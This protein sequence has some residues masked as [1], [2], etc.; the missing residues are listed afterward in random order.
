VGERRLA[1][2]MFTDM[3]GYTA[4]SQK[5]EQRAMLQLDEHRKLV[6]PIFSRHNGHEVKTIGDAFL[7]EFASALEAVRCAFDIQQCLHELNSTRTVDDRMLLRISVHV[8]D[9]IH[10]GN[11]VYGDAVNVASRM[12]PLA[13]PGGIC[14]SEQVY[15]HVRNKFEFPLVSLGRKELKNVG[16]GVELYRVVLPWEAEAETVLDKQ[17][18]AVLPFDSLS[19]D[20]NDEYFADGLTEELIDRL[21]QIGGL[22]VIART[23]V[24]SYKR[25]GKKAAEIARELSVGSLVEGSVRK[26]GNKVRVTAQLINGVTE[27]HLWSSRY[28]KSLD[29]IFAVQSDIAEQVSDALKIRLLPNESEAIKKKATV[30]TEAHNLFLKGRHF[31]SQRNPES[32]QRAIICFEQAVEIDPLFALAYV[33][34]ADCYLV[35]LDQSAVEPTGIDQKIESLAGRALELDSGLA[36][37]HA[38]LANLLQNRWNW[39]EAEAEYKRAIELN[40]NYATSHH[41]YSILL[42]RF[43][44]FDQALDEIRIAHRLDP[45][46]PM[47]NVN[48]GLRLVEAGHL[49]EGLEQLRSS[50]QLDP[51]FGQGHAQLGATYVGMGRYEEGILELEK[52]DEIMAGSPWAKALLAYTFGMKGEQAKAENY[53]KEIENLART[54]YVPSALLGTVYFALGQKEKA[55]ELFQRAYDERSIALE[56]VREFLVYRPIREDQRI[57]ALLE[58]MVSNQR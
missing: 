19:P 25:K 29:D 48:L 38:S 45:I 34:L 9:V 10:S 50:I 17:R 35:L 49:D 39:K 26:A 22:E 42:T 27:G 15:D 33:G 23:S 43:D 40:P 3:V 30:S 24:M 6:R 16:G 44:K 1:A 54:K 57:R 58:R 18:I 46:S 31:F 41:W 51:N 11:D 52:A 7:V 4:L 5:N 47:V 36:E 12:E 28:D 37:A 20:P 13:S 21:C 32:V 14:V 53:L 8:G 2:I 56:Y 55:L